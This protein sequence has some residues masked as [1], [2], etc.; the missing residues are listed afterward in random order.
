MFLMIFSCAA[1]AYAAQK[2]DGSRT[3]GRQSSAVIKMRKLE[4]MPL[5]N[6]KAVKIYSKNILKF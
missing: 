1:S 2:R 3:K 4:R 6:V 5:S